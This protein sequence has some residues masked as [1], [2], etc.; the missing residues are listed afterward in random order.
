MCGDFKT[1]CL[2]IDVGS[3]I[4][5]NKEINQ[6]KNSI[7]ISWSIFKSRASLI[8]P[9]LV[10]RQKLLILTVFCTELRYKKN[11]LLDGQTR[12]AKSSSQLVN[13]PGA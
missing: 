13:L 10:Y 11:F 3:K 12:Q 5:Q 6:N 8:C 2:S 7:S 1:V 9:I 4:L